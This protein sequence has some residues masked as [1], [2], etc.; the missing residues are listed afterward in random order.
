MKLV[1]PRAA[2]VAASLVLALPLLAQVQFSTGFEPNSIIRKNDN[3][4]VLATERGREFFGDDLSRGAR[5]SDWI[6]N[7]NTAVLGGIQI[8]YQSKFPGTW[9]AT[10][11]EGSENH[12]QFA[13]AKIIDTTGMGA[14]HAG[15]GNVLQFWMK[16]GMDP[17]P[18]G[19]PVANA[20]KG[21]V[22]VN[23]GGANNENQLNEATS[24]VKLFIPADW[25]SL[26]Q[27]DDTLRWLTIQEFWSNFNNVGGDEAQNFRITIGLNKAAAVGSPLFWTV[28]CDEAG[29][30]A[31]GTPPGPI[32]GET[33]WESDTQAQGVF[34]DNNVYGKWITLVSYYLKSTTVDHY[35]HPIVLVNGKPVIQQGNG[36][37]RLKAIYA[38]GTQQEL[39]DIAGHTRHGTEYVN[40]DKN[41][42]VQR[43][44]FN[45]DKGLTKH[46]PMKLYTH[47]SNIDFMRNLD[48]VNFTKVLSM[49]WDDWELYQGNFYDAAGLVPESENLAII[50]S[51]GTVGNPAYAFAS[52]NPAKYRDLTNTVA[53]TSFLNQ[54]V[55]IPAAGTYEVVAEFAK[56]QNRGKYEFKIDNVIYGA[57]QDLY[58]A[59]VA[60]ATP[61]MV[62]APIATM[63]LAAGNRAFRFNAKTKNAASTG[64]D[65][66][67][68]RFRLNP[69]REAEAVPDST[70]AGTV[71]NTTPG[72]SSGFYRRF[73]GTLNATITYTVN[74]PAAGTYHVNLGVVTGPNGGIYRL[75]ADGVPVGNLDNY[76][77]GTAV[78]ATRDVGTITFDTAG[79]KTFVFTCL[80]KQAAANNSWLE[81]DYIKLE[82]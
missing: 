46:N 70:P 71:V 20:N 60:A 45:N 39:F 38:D 14:A 75:T 63:P 21:R 22:E 76:K 26:E 33:I 15:R 1:T 6:A 4:P 3:S 19:A 8:N 67:L 25:Q 29:G 5:P 31:S 55:N 49:L 50:G 23:Y 80:G 68:D 2:L 16:D 56:A 79:N 52:G 57:Q 12:N 65:F 7:F 72:A 30:G 40:N 35:V 42:G 73:Q 48:P 43:A 27:K 37:F 62:E 11:N 41:A 51:S 18:P 64:N 58:L 82:P 44:P 78:I 36:R 53:N 77:P 10:N 61:V 81:L 9:T 13:F 24:V 32:L 74:V 34:L 69:F 66:G 28:K 59:G 47:N 54:T 17:N